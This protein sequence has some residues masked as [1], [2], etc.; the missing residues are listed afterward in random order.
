MHELIQQE[1][2]QLLPAKRKRSNDWISFNAVCCT[3]RGESRDTRSRGGVRPNP[4][5]SI[6]YHCFNCGFKTG[7][8]PGRPMGF[9]FRNLLKW[10][11]ADDN[12][13]QRLVMEALRVKELVPV[14]ERVLVPEVEVNF[15]PRPLPD[16]S[17][18]I[19]Q[20]ATQIRLSVPWRSDGLV[21]WHD[22]QKAIPEQL[23]QAVSYLH[24]RSVEIKKYDFYL[25]DETSYNLNKRVIVPFTWKNQIIGYTAR[26]LTNDIKPKYHNSH[27]PNYVFNLDKQLPDGKFVLV[28]EGPFDAMSVDGVAILGNDCN[29]TQAEI[30]ESLGRDVIVVPDFDQHIDKRGKSVWPGKQLIDRA[31]KYGWGVAFPIW[32]EDEECKDVSSAVVKYGKL[33]VLKSIVDSVEHNPVKIKLR[34]K[35]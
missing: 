14:T 20:W 4:D 6:N 17:A 12:T 25:T 13:V 24:E 11:G 5:G 27:E 10:F 30:I 26:A 33:F 2:L 22:L 16:N 29:D 8:Y 34:C 28:V 15:K 19:M 9:K 32:R 1:L 18:T 21:E 3:H 31:I 7:Y 35:Q 23:E